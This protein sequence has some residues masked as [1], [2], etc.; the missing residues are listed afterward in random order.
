MRKSLAAALFGALLVTACSLGTDTSEQLR[1]DAKTSLAKFRAGDAV[2][3]TITV[4]NES[5]SSVDLPVGSCPSHFAVRDASGSIVGPPSE[6]CTAQLIVKTLAPGEKAEYTST[7]H[8]EGFATSTG[9]TTFLK[10]GMY[11]VEGFFGIT[12][13]THPATVEI[14]A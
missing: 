3:V 13:D 14:T 4:T 1:V 8:G 5:S 12:T 11:T 2:L 7:W 10:P 6:V 9:Q